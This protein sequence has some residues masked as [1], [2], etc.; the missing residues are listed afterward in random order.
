LEK[1][2]WTLQ[3]LL[4]LRRKARQEDAK[5]RTAAERARMRGKAELFSGNVDKKR[6]AS[7]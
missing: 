7:C 5:I 6:R 4:A 1:V 2:L 3:N